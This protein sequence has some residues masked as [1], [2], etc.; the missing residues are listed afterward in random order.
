MRFE[1]V[2]TNSQRWSHIRLL[3]DVPQ[4]SFR[5]IKYIST[6]TN[7]KCTGSVIIAL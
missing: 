5:C 3:M 6:H 7:G 2:R 4:V 1:T